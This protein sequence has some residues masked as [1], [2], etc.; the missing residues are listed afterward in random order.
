MAVGCHGFRPRNPCGRAPAA[1]HGFR[2]R[3]PWHPG[4]ARHG[5]PRRAI[6]E[7]GRGPRGS[8][9][10]GAGG[11]NPGNS[12]GPLFDACGNVVGV[13]T[14]KTIS[15]T[16]VDSYGIAVGAEALDRFLARHLGGRVYRPSPPLRQRYDWAA[17]DRSVSPSVVQVLRPSP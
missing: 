17:L 7:R 3:N 9:E 11:V 2:G 8:P 1:A 13:V 6:S 15:T 4:L 12:G 5:R 14:A 16:A 10:P